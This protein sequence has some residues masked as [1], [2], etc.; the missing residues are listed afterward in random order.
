MIFRDLLDYLEATPNVS[1]L[2]SEDVLAD[3]AN[4]IVGNEPSKFSIAPETPVNPYN[5][6]A[7]KVFLRSLPKGGQTVISL[8]SIQGG[9]QKGRLYLGVIGYGLEN[10]LGGAVVIAF[11]SVKIYHKIKSGDIRYNTTGN[12]LDRIGEPYIEIPSLL[13][14]FPEYRK[15]ARNAGR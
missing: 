10:Y 15:L 5:S 8:P 9:N 13:K 1:V 7:M 4:T 6:D 12:R 11:P 2:S 3:D 14:A